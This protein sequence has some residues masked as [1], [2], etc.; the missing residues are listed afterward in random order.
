MLI[1]HF[2]K[3]VSSMYVSISAFQVSSPVRFF[4]IPRY[5]IFVFLFLTYFTPVPGWEEDR[6]YTLL[7]VKE[8]GLPWWLRG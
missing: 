8:I 3:Q 5:L 1:E 7:Y 4:K 2:L 6:I